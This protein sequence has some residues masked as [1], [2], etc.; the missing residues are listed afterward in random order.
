MKNSIR[1]SKLR[2]KK[3]KEK[4]EKLTFG[5]LLRQ[6]GQN[7][8]GWWQDDDQ[9]WQSHMNRQ[10][11]IG[12]KKKA[13]GR[14]QNKLTKSGF[15]KT[16]LRHLKE[17]SGRRSAERKRMQKLRKENPK[18]YRAIKKEQRK[19]DRLKLKKKSRFGS[20]RPGSF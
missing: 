20:K 14:I 7:I 5:D 1:R 9:P 2:R 3:E 13:S 6:G 8:K 11:G 18:K 15:S 16:E 12:D 10:A 17:A 4:A 19:K